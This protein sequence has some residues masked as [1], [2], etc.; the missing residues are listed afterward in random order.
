MERLV[1]YQITIRPYEVETEKLVWAGED[2]R[3]ELL[4]RKKVV[5]GQAMRMYHALLEAGVGLCDPGLFENYEVVIVPGWNPRMPGRA[6]R[7][8]LLQSGNN[9]AF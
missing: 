9:S 4:H 8:T 5:P 3:F 6:L 7:P 1:G 2:Y